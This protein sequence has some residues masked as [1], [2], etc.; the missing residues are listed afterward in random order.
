MNLA[1]SDVLLSYFIGC[2]TQNK[3]P[4][5]HTSDCRLSCQHDVALTPFLASQ[6]DEKVLSSHM[7][8]KNR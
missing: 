7:A 2:Y 3:N 5:S 6:N 8:R 1:S 4:V